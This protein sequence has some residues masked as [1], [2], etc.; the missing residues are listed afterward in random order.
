MKMK[1]RKLLSIV[2]AVM[3]LF[4]CF[5]A[6][7]AALKL[8]VELGENV[9]TEF[10]GISKLASVTFAVAPEFTE[11]LPEAEITVHYSAEKEENFFDAF[12]REPVG[13]V[14]VGDIYLAD[15]VLH[16]N[17][18]GLNLSA[19]GYYYITVGGGSLGYVGEYDVEYINGSYTAED[20]EH[21]FESLDIGEK[22]SCFFDY[23]LNIIMNLISNGKTY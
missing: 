9:A 21:R 10:Y 22:I 3:M 4:G 5:S 16:V 18:A 23:I 15:G 19:E 13:T 6:S 2:M 1:T 12:D 11:V 20:Y 8:P 14:G 17:L 7:A